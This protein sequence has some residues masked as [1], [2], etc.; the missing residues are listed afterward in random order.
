MP[1]LTE[2]STQV[3][4]VVT[5][6]FTPTPIEIPTPQKG[7]TPVGLS[8]TKS[9]SLATPPVISTSDPFIA[10]SQAVKDGSCLVVTP[11]SIPSSA[12]RGPNAGLSSD[13]GS[14]EVFENS[15]NELVVKT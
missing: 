4:R 1:W 2:E 10:L 5:G 3:E 8:L 12:T 11:S 6:E 7:I 15:K 9:T 14:E 13:E